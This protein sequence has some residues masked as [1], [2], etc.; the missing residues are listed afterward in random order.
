M[1]RANNFNPGI[2]SAVA[3]HVDASSGS[4]G[5]GGACPDLLVARLR[6]HT[7]G[8]LLRQVPDGC[9]RQAAVDLQAHGVHLC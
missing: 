6:H 9:A 7:N 2:E 1:A 8:A 4:I 5:V 3:P